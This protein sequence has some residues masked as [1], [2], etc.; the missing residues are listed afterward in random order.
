MYLFRERNHKKKHP[1]VELQGHRSPVRMP[2]PFHFP[3]VKKTVEI[4][5]SGVGQNCSPL[6]ISGKR[7]GNRKTRTGESVSSAVSLAHL[8]RGDDE[9]RDSTN[10]PAQI[11]PADLNMLFSKRDVTDNILIHNVCLRAQHSLMKPRITVIHNYLL[12][13]TTRTLRKVVAHKISAYLRGA[14]GYMQ[15]SKTDL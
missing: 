9:V 6:A 3:D 11:L 2:F 12:V 8:Q 1:F 14:S 13:I 15:F 4:V 10:Y 7:Q 5:L